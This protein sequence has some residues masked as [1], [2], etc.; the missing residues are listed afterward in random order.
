MDRENM[1]IQAVGLGWDLHRLQAGRPLVLCN[2]TIP[3]E[4]GLLGHSD[5]DVAL[6]AVTDALL[7]AA[8]LG[9]IGEKYPP[10]DPQWRGADS[11]QLL[12]MVLEDV[13]RA[14][15]QVVNVDLTIITEMPKMGP[16]KAQMRQRLAELLDVGRER[17]N[18]KAKTSEG[19][20]AVGR[21]EA[22]AAQ[23]IVGLGRRDEESRKQ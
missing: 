13:R 6:H 23:A 2:V 7:G 18:I 20:D 8:G 14:G 19:V 1:T 21:G 4:K 11:G 22:M 15:W 10:S 16:H 9:D 5:A 17:V 12:Q 3:F